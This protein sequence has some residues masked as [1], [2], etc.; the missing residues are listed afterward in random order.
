M[1]SDRPKTVP[2]LAESVFAVWCEDGPAAAEARLLELDGHLAHIERHHDRYLIAGPLRPGDASA[3]CGSLLLVLAET[4]EEARQLMQGDPY[5][6]QGA[7]AR[8]E[9][10]R[11]TPA[12][13][14]W[15]GGVIWESADQLRPHA[16]G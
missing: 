1:R 9:F 3:I 14:R 15:L 16:R 11:L 5:V 6:T 8:M 2:R 7:F 13:G 4:E 10:R 12:A